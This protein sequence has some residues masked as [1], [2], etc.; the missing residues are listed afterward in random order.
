MEV[1][2][3]EMNAVELVRKSS[4]WLK[5][6]K[7]TED[8]GGE[9]FCLFGVGG[10]IACILHLNG[11]ENEKWNSYFASLGSK[12]QMGTFLRSVIRQE[13]MKVKETN[14]EC[15]ECYILTLSKFKCDKRA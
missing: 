15:S 5:L 8:N 1:K 13:E 10:R 9:L 14:L 11:L 4:N 3:I 2:W 12:A 7:K 6:L